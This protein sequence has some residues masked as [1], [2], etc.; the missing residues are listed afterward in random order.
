[1]PWGQVVIGPPGCGKTTYCAGMAKLLEL[2]GRRT[3][4]VN[5]DPA[6]DTLPYTAGVDIAKVGMPELDRCRIL[7][8]NYNLVAGFNSIL[9]VSCDFRC[10]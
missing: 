7:L 10:V 4:V 6:N 1:M 8:V 3:V 9:G 5:L 2:L